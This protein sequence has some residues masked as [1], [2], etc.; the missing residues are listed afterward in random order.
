MDDGDQ[1]ETETRAWMHSNL[2][3]AA[4]HFAVTVAG[5]PVWGWWLRSISAPVDDH[6]HEPRWLRVGAERAVDVEEM[7]EFWRGLVDA[8][9]VTGVA[10]PVVV[11]SMEWDEPGRGQRVR[12]DLMT[13]VTGRPCSHTE[14][15]AARPDL[16]ESWWAD[17]RAAVDTI[18]AAPT[19][20][21]ANRR[22]NGS[23][24]VRTVFGDEVADAYQLAE[25]ETVH[26]DLHWANILGPE[27]VILDW[28]L[29]GRGP[30]GTDAATLYLFALPVPDV[31]HRVHDLFAD[32]LDSPAGRIAQI[33]VASRILYRAEQHPHLAQAARE[34][35]APLLDPVAVE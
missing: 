26:G 32:V 13:R 1:W 25:I 24:R 15:L 30:T 8:N 12:A 23:G 19:D 28:E 31:A 35:I 16:P 9:S 4:D 10:K 22:G 18:R 2:A 5:A 6:D 3:R 14:A 17:L 11:D 27:L 21:Y 20:R 7:P 34:H 29:W 33:G